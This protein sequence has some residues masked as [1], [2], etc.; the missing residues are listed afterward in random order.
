MSEYK[1]TDE[2]IKAIVKECPQS[3][4]A[5]KAAFPEAFEEIWA[6]V[7]CSRIRIR[8]EQVT[9]GAFMLSV[10]VDGIR[11]GEFIHDGL[12]ITSNRHSKAGETLPSMFTIYEKK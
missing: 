5:L 12:V 8:I 10:M 4:E 6:S 11:V 1:V 9:G 3:R 7:D 2:A